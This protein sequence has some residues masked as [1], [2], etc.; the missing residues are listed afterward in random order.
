ML[1]NINS[2]KSANFRKMFYDKFCADWM[3]LPQENEHQMRVI[4][5]KSKD[6]M[7][8]LHYQVVFDPVTK[9][10]QCYISSVKP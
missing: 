9:D 8:R 5:R 7:I 10:K 3:F 6:H 4:Q 2:N 1:L